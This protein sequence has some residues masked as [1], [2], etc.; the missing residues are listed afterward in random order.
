[1]K[2]EDKNLLNLPK[3]LKD[4][5]GDKPV[6]EMNDA[7]EADEDYR[8]DYRNKAEFTVGESYEERGTSKVGFNQGNFGKG[9]MFVRDASGT[10]MVSRESI[11]IAKIYEDYIKKSPYRYYDRIKHDGV[12]RNLVVRH[13][14]TT[15]E[16][17]INVVLNK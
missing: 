12:W 9:F 14:E 1:M 13:S 11:E 5:K 17:L 7:I 16:M 15:N 2:S 10:R 4:N 6:C 3:W 8:L